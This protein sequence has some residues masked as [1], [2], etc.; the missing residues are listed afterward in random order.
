MKLQ[1]LSIRLVVVLANTLQESLGESPKTWLTNSSRP[2]ANLKGKENPDLPS[3]CSN[4]WPPILA[5]S[6]CYNH[7][8]L[9]I[10]WQ[11]RPAMQVCNPREIRQAHSQYPPLSRVSLRDPLFN[12][13]VHA[14][15]KVLSSCNFM[16]FSSRSHHFC[17][18]FVSSDCIHL[19]EKL[20]K[21]LQVLFPKFFKPIFGWFLPFKTTVPAAV[22]G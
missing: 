7:L 14:K 18:I 3:V 2:P 11:C 16:N 17:I 6:L 21:M 10:F 5:L 15:T 9:S 1:I 22:A 13:F 19:Y 20:V 4:Y 12:V 8:V